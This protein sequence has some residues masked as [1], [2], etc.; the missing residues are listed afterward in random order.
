LRPSALSAGVGKAGRQPVRQ[1]EHRRCVERSGWQSLGGGGLPR[2]SSDERLVSQI[3]SQYAR[4]L[5]AGSG[6]A[7]GNGGVGDG[8]NS[9][10]GGGSGGGDGDNGGVMG[11]GFCSGLGGGPGFGGGGGGSGTWLEVSAAASATA[12]AAA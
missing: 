5:L 10:N 3:T 12:S 6:G 11:G 2:P 1:L 8:G 4:Q 9:G 7:D